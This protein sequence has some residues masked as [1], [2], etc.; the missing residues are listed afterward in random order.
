[1]PEARCAE[2]VNALGDRLVELRARRVELAALVAAPAPQAQSDETLA[3]LRGHIDRVM[4]NGDEAQRKAV[5]QALVQ[6]VRVVSRDEILPTFYVPED[7]D[8]AKVLMPDGIV[9][10]ASGDKNRGPVLSG[11]A[12]SLA[13]APNRG[14]P[15][16]RS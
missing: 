16:A 13:S 4:K 2:R 6:E 9:D 15:P 5:M 8:P 3:L 11:G 14:R 12:V 1:M 10:I 7:S